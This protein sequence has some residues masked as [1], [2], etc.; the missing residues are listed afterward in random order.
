MAWTSDTAPGPVSPPAKFQRGPTNGVA[1][2]R[3]AI[4]FALHP[5]ENMTIVRT[6]E[7]SRPKAVDYEIS[8]NETWNY[9]LDMSAQPRF[10]RAPS[11]K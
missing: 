9:A 2:S 4:V 5:K 10:V 3:G 11:A 1:I 6:Y 7:A 8:T